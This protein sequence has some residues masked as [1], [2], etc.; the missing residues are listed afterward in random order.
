M[1]PTKK[2]LRVS[3]PS[4][5]PEG[6]EIKLELG[7]NWFARWR[8]EDPQLE[9][10]TAAINGMVR[11][12]KHGREVLVRG[13]L[14][15]HL[16]LACGRC[17]ES[18]AAPAE[19]DFDLLLVPVPGKAAGKDEELNAA[20][21]DVDFYTGEIVD[22]ETILREQIILL[23]PLKPLCRED[24]RGLCPHCGAVLDQEAC[25]CKKN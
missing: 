15:G 11:L 6:L 17:L 19:G 13:R 3:L 2:S 10:A 23:M 24:C 21:L 8:E 18:Y 5:P 22:L 16:Q 14:Q 20:D 7:D 25:S 12:E 1:M 4:I 9:F